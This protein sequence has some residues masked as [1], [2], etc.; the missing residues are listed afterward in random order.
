M[1]EIHKKRYKVK[2][3]Q[4]FEEDY[5]KWRRDRMSDDNMTIESQ[6]ISRNIFLNFKTRSTREK[7]CITLSEQC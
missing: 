1:I 5:K 4:L 6:Y 3:T 2:K 7:I